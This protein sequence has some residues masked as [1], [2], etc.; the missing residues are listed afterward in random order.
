MQAYKQTKVIPVKYLNF[1]T[2]CTM[3]IKK[4]DEKKEKKKEKKPHGKTRFPV[5]GI[6]QTCEQQKHTK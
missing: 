6:L 2:M 1:A 4:T 5:T 3:R